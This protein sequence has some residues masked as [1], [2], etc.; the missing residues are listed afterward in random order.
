MI[1]IFDEIF[2]DASLFILA[3]VNKCKASN[4]WVVVVGDTRNGEKKD[5][6]TESEIL[7]S[8]TNLLGCILISEEERN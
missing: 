6:L 5:H 1:P 8:G 2:T 7:S 3:R 4:T